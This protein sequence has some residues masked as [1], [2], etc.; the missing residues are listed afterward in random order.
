M[1][2][3]LLKGTWWLIDSIW[4][5]LSYLQYI[6]CLGGDLIYDFLLVPLTILT[7]VTVKRLIQCCHIDVEITLITYLKISDMVGIHCVLKIP[8]W[9]STTYL[10]LGGY[11]GYPKMGNMVGIHCKSKMSNIVS[12]HHSFKIS[13]TVGIHH[14]VKRLVIW[15]VST[16]YWKIGNMG[17]HHIV[18]SLIW[19]VSAVYSKLARQWVCT[20]W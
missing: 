18:R 17:I 13:E 12:I 7:Y 2:H 5:W 9:V 4:E 10:K 3:W 14:M 11:G 16:T 6:A 1:R 20:T 8:W 15:W 19:W